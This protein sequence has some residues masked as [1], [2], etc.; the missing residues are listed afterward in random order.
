MPISEYAAVIRDGLAKDKRARKV[1]MVGGGMG[2]VVAGVELLRAGH[3]PI[4]LEAQ[5]RVGGRVYTV[6]EPFSDGLHGEAG[7]MRIPRSHALTMAYIERFGLRTLPFTMNNPRAYYFLNGRHYRVA[8]AN[9]DPNMLGFDCLPA[10]RGRSHNQLWSAALQPLLAK[11]EQDPLAAWDEIVSQYDQYSTREFLE[12]CGW[13][14]GA[15]E[16]FGL[17]ADQEA[18]MNSSFLELFREEAGNYYSDMVQI[19]DG[20]DH[21]PRAFL[22]E[23]RRHIRFGARMIALEQSAASATVVYETAAG[24]F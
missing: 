3:H 19:E 1:V 22:P 23:L 12:T 7:A 16:M 14:E 24:R 15:I 8:E 6:R 17:L 5:N 2:G 11:L 9:S 18:L 4:I 21:L 20:Q 10:E 13:S